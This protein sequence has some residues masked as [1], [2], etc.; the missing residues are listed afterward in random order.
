MNKQEAKTVVSVLMNNV[1]E[2]K[3]KKPFVVNLSANVSIPKHELLK[4]VA[5]ENN[6]AVVRFRSEQLDEIGM[7]LEN[8]LPKEINE[9]MVSNQKE[10]QASLGE[11]WKN[12]IS[13]VVLFFEEM[14]RV[15]EPTAEANYITLFREHAIGNYTLPT[16]W[17]MIGS[18]S[19]NKLSMELALPMIHFKIKVD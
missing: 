6:M 17:M 13:G 9:R 4:E 11:N 8:S 3:T 10:L 16:K 12:K 19:F 7:N 15:K 14:E 18:T 1:I 2:E 5:T